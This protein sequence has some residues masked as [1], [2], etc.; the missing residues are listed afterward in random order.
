MF[1]WFSRGAPYQCSKIA[2]NQQKTVVSDAIFTIIINVDVLAT[3]LA[4][5]NRIKVCKILCKAATK[6]VRATTSSETKNK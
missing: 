4:A 2:T 5:T 6:S 1:M 3:H